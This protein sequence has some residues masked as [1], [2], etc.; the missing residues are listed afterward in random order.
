MPK[1]PEQRYALMLVVVLCR[2]FSSLSPFFLPISPSLSFHIFSVAFP[3]LLHQRIHLSCPASPPPCLSAAVFTAD[4]VCHPHY[5]VAAICPQV[6]SRSLSIFLQSVAVLTTHFAISVVP[7]IICCRP[8]YP[9]S[10]YPSL[11]Y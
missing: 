9:P 6:G 11:L 2:F 8:T 7:Y 1:L 4:L 10:P 3:Q 5:P